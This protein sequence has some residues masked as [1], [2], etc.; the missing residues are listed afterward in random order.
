MVCG[1]PFASVITIISEIDM[2]AD[3][4]APPVPVVK[5]CALEATQALDRSWS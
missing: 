3:G 4:Q 2:N 1:G 5:K